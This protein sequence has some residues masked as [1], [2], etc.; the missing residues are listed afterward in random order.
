MK[1]NYNP[2]KLGEYEIGWWIAH[3]DKDKE[4]L[5]KY[6]AL[7]NIELYGVNEEAAAE[8]SVLLFT[9]VKLH[10]TRD[11]ECAISQMEQFYNLV[12]LQKGYNFDSHKVAELEVGWWEL[13]DR[14]EHNPDKTELT[15]AFSKLYGSIFS[16][17]SE[18]LVEAGKERAA[19]TYEHDL[20][21]DP[22]TPSDEVKSHWEK[23]KQHL[24]TFYTML[25]NQIH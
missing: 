15:I 25:K 2:S 22:D 8:M 17:P 5:K 18:D 24:V 23:A 12:K 16:I 13:H 3:N 7:Q 10:N 6:L 1:L 20:A 11:W 19:A 14:L 21:E 4:N 9:A